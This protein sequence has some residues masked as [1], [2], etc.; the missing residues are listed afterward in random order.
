MILTLRLFAVS[1]KVR[2]YATAGI[3]FV[4]VVIKALSFVVTLPRTRSLLKI[5]IEL[6]KT[7]SLLRNSNTITFL[8]QEVHWFAPK[9][10]NFTQGTSLRLPS[11]IPSPP[12]SKYVRT[13][14]RTMYTDVITN[15][16]FRIDRFSNF[17]SN[18]TYAVNFIKRL[19][20]TAKRRET[21]LFVN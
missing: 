18:G 17:F 21:V 2:G 6:I 8:L 9:Q 10:V 14:E 1:S 16:F 5:Y 11:H 15:F 3:S 20:V 4:T 13:D 19:P 7:I 12:P